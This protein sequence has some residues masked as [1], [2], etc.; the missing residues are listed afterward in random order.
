MGTQTEPR[1]C[2]LLSQMALPYWYLSVPIADLFHEFGPARDRSLAN[3]TVSLIRYGKYTPEFDR[4]SCHLSAAFVESRRLRSLAFWFGRRVIHQPGCFHISFTQG[5][6]RIGTKQ[7]GM[8]DL[9]LAEQT[10]EAWMSKSE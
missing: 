10:K 2:K 8:R 3:D 1:T 9:P 6:R 4:R 7:T 5:T